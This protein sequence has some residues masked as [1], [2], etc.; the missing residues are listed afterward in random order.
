MK[1]E[2]IRYKHR[3][4]YGV[5]V[6]TKE[7]GDPKCHGIK[8]AKGESRLLYHVKNILNSQGYDLI[9]K[10]IQKD[11]HM[12]GD[13]Y[14]QYLRTRK[15]SSDPEKNIYIYNGRYQIEG[16]EEDFNRQGEVRLMV[17]FDVFKKAEEDT[18]Q[19]MT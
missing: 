7:P 4:E 1:V 14:Q 11:G 19:I 3:T 13:Q 15:P 16:A 17:V 18:H 12:M 8:F 10:R 9:K 5:C 2:I 6:V